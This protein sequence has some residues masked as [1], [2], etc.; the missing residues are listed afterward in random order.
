MLNRTIIDFCQQ[1]DKC[2]LWK[3][4][5]FCPNCLVR[6]IINTSEPLAHVR[7]NIPGVKSCIGA[8]QAVRVE[9]LTAGS[10]VS[11]GD[12]RV[13]LRVTELPVYEGPL[14]LV[15]RLCFSHTPPL[16]LDTCDRCVSVP[17]SLYRVTERHTSQ[18]HTYCIRLACYPFTEIFN[19][20]MAS[21]WVCLDIS[22]LKWPHRLHLNVFLMKTN[23]LNKERML[24]CSI[25]WWFCGRFIFTCSAMIYYLSYRNDCSW[26]YVPVS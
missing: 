15:L 16:L 11:E 22:P 19:F 21:A 25:A 26:V 8:G 2:A 6:N 12:S 23:G 5:L 17:W 14:A 1:I 18:G 24:W 20:H 3:S 7:F 9:C 4:F 10:E 13:T